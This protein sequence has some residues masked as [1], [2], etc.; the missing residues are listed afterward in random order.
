MN[1]IC[2]LKKWSARSKSS[3]DKIIQFMVEVFSRR[4][5][6]CYFFPSENATPYV[7]PGRE[8]W[9][10]QSKIQG[11]NPLQTRK[12]CQ[13]LPSL[14]RRKRYLTFSWQNWD[15]GSLQ[16]SV[17]RWGVQ[18]PST[19]TETIWAWWREQVCWSGVIPQPLPGVWVIHPAFFPRSIGFEQMGLKSNLGVPDTRKW[20]SV[21]VGDN[22]IVRSWKVLDCWFSFEGC[23]EVPR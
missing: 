7:S 2:N 22:L 19:C 12:D 11:C 14:S 15:M 18:S 9:S 4:L 13:L 3:I 1:G 6:G 16:T 23:H 5:L 17:I 20:L 10:H 8:E 21:G